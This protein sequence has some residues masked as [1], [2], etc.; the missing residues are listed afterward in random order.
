MRRPSRLRLANAGRLGATSELGDP[1]GS[2]LESEELEPAQ[3][4]NLVAAAA[5]GA[6]RTTWE[7][8]TCLVWVISPALSTRVRVRVC[9]RCRSAAVLQG[10][11]AWRLWRGAAESHHH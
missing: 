6:L 2:M 10:D 3:R 8:P 11:T 9:P 4:S 7:R 5:G 1:L